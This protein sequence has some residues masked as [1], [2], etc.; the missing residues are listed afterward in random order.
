[1]GSEMKY[2]PTCGVRQNELPTGVSGNKSRSGQALTH[3][4]V[5]SV[6]LRVPPLAGARR[7]RVGASV[8]IPSVPVSQTTLTELAL[9]PRRKRVMGGSRLG[10]PRFGTTGRSKDGNKLDYMKTDLDILDI[11]FSIFFLSSLG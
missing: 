11:H 6:P 5:A 2:R 8:I 1:M 3:A 10:T 7:P 4:H 9:R